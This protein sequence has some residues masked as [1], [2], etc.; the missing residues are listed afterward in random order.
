MIKRSK[1]K[2]VVVVIILTGRMETQRETPKEEEWMEEGR[3]GF[4]GIV[5][6]EQVVSL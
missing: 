2:W 6:R 4:A 5:T 1:P 3:L